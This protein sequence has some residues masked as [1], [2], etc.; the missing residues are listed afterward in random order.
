MNIRNIELYIKHGIYKS[1]SRKQK[2]EWAMATAYLGLMAGTYGFFVNNTTKIYSVLSY[3]CAI[4]I[5]AISIIMTKK[6]DIKRL[7]RYNAYDSLLCTLMFVFESAI[8]FEALKLNCS[9]LICLIPIITVFLAFFKTTNN[10]KKGKYN[11]SKT[12]FKIIVST[13]LASTFTGSAIC[14]SMPKNIS[15]SNGFIILSIFLL[16]VSCVFSLGILN[17]LKL[18]YIKHLENQG[19]K[20]EL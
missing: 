20:I 18:Y 12:N 4:S 5:V 8:Y 11:K 9:F 6:L 13:A 15:S 16:V 7:V 19:Y 1:Q 17:F 2:I 3:L 10:V 14:S